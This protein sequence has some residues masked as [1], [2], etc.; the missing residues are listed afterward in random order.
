MTQAYLLVRSELG[1][2]VDVRER[3][4]RLPEVREAHVVYGVYDLVVRVEA[5]DA[6]V[7]KNTVFSKIRKMGGVRSTLTMIVTDG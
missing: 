3:L 1:S 4:R 6:E 7:L 5:E 2:E